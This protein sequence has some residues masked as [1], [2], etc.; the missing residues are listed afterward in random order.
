MTVAILWLGMKGGAAAHAPNLAAFRRGTRR[1][2]DPERRGE[3]GP[4]RR[5]FPDARSAYAGRRQALPLLAG[6]IPFG[7]MTGY[8]PRRPAS[9]CRRPAMTVMVF[10]GTA[11]IAT[12]P[13]MVAGAPVR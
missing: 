5:F 11:Q 9:A 12:L 2:A 1:P 3:R 7:P 6:T 13:L 8:R 10:A 4:F